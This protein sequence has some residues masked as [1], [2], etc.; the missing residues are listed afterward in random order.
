MAL[1]I[2]IDYDNTYTAA[3]VLWLQFI[4]MA[5]ARGDQVVICTA[6]AFPPTTHLPVDVHCTA[7]QAKVT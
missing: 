7:G 3:P 1:L 2:S 4:A 6:R 5:V